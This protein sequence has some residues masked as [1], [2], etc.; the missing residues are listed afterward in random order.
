MSLDVSYILPVLNEAD[1]LEKAVQSV[2]DQDHDGA[3]ELIIALAP[4]TDGTNAIL[5]R[6]MALHPQIRIVDNPKRD[7]P[8]GLNLAIAETRHPVV[9]RVDA[10]S[11]IPLDYTRKGVAALERVGA[12]NVG[13][14]MDATGDTAFQQAVAHAYTS[15][16]G[17]GNVSYHVGTEE[18]P[19]ESAYLGVFRREVL[20]E[21]GGF[22]ETIRRGEDWELNQRIIAAGHIVWFSPELRVK[23]WPRDSWGNLARQFFA[24]GVWRGELLRRLGT[25]NSL[26]YFAPPLLVL[27]LVAGVVGAIV[28]STGAG[29]TFLRAV[30]ALALLPGLTYLALI[31]TVAASASLSLRAR[32]WYLAVLPT[33]HI[34]WGS[35]FLWGAVRGA[36]KTI[37]TSRA[38]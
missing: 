38:D 10:H 29:S 15:K 6:L 19:A 5:E 28:L 34:A 27:G 13:G 17:M 14:V 24:T 35:G 4:S 22:D 32:L 7:I 26:R 37:D 11:E 3:T 30:C 12:A 33:M 18:G 16:V 9:I 20:V 36:H 25:S 21:V 1:Y 31:V 2:L 8:I 23:Y